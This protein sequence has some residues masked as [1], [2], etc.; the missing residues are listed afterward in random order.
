M[1]PELVALLMKQANHERYAAACYTAMA[2]WCE[3]EDYA[4]FAEFLHSQAKEEIEHSEKFFGHL[5]DRDIQPV[6]E[7]LPAPRGEFK[8][9]L[10]LAELSLHLEQANTKGIHECYRAAEEHKDA[11]CLPLLLEFISEQVEEEAWANKMIALLRRSD[12]AGAIYNLD[13]HIVK[14]LG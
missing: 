5:L 7:A 14:E 10:E 6:L 8:A 4:G 13:R 1:I 12:C 2:Y 9:L 3:A 11:A